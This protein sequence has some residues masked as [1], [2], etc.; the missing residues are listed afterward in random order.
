MDI[1]NLAYLLSYVRYIYNNDILEDLLFCQP[2]H[3]RTTGM[4]IFQIVENFFAQVF[5]TDCVG[6]CTDGAAAIIGHTAGFHAECDL[7]MI[8]LLLLQTL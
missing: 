2:L 8:H 6:V 1:T 5:W 4:D 3:G 7:Q